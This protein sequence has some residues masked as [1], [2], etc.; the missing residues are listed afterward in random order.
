MFLVTIMYYESDDDVK[1]KMKTHM[2]HEMLCGFLTISLTDENTTGAQ[3]SFKEGYIGNL[4]RD[5]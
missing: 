5:D 3:L 4:N 1:S 2:Q